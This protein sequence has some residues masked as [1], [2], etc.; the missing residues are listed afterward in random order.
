MDTLPVH[1]ILSQVKAMANSKFQAQPSHVVLTISL[2]FF[3]LLLNVVNS[4]SFQA[5]NFPKFVPNQPN[6]IL[7]GDALIT[8]TGKLQLTE[9]DE[10]GRPASSSLGRALYSAP[11]QIWD[12]STGIS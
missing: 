4:E 5:F 9:V 6:L 3:L 11:I 2:T 1:H 8:S 10:R 12:S 7:Q